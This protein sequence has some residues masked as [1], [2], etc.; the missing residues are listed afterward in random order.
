M[1]RLT[2]PQIAGYANLQEAT[3][4]VKLVQDIPR[5]EISDA[6]QIRIVEVKK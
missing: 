5:I 4:E 3:A 1:T 2:S 6:K